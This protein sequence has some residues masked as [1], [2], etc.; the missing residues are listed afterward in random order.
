MQWEN[1]DKR[2]HYKCWIPQKEYTN[3]LTSHKKWRLVVVDLSLSYKIRLYSTRAAYHKVCLL[4]SSIQLLSLGFSFLHQ[5][6]PLENDKNIVER[7]I[8]PLTNKQILEKK[9]I[10]WQTCFSSLIWRSSKVHFQPGNLYILKTF[11]WYYL[12]LFVE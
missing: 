6:F 9:N 11:V 4:P 8:K 2:S 1:E 7:N 12:K 5:K 3:Q 10:I